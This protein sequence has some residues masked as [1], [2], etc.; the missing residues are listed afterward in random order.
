[1]AKNRDKDGWNFT[2]SQFRNVRVSAVYLLH[3]F[4]DD[5]F[6]LL[7][8][9]FLPLVKGFYGRLHLIYS[10]LLDLLFLKQRQEAVGREKGRQD[11]KA[12]WCRAELATATFS[13]LELSAWARLWWLGW[14]VVE[15]G[16]GWLWVAAVALVGVGRRAGFAKPTTV[17]AI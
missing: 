3:C 5:L 9:D 17:F 11:K 16:S 14:A 13:F 8:C 15:D 10:F 1:M 7:L 4:A 2:S 12:L 6:V